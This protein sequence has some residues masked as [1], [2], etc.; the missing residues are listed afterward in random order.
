MFRN[1]RQ[2]FCTFITNGSWENR[3]SS[4]KD[5]HRIHKENNKIQNQDKTLIWYDNNILIKWKKSRLCLLL[6][7]SQPM[8]IEQNI[9]DQW[10]MTITLNWPIR[11]EQIKYEPMRIKKS[12]LKDSIQSYEQK[13]GWFSSQLLNFQWSQGRVF[14]TTFAKKSCIFKIFLP[15]PLP[16]LIPLFPLFL[17]PLPFF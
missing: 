13:K 7:F 11:V 14:Y 3:I 8:K 1:N 12:V 17:P 5:V 15:Y 2:K 6:I 10:K 4:K 9:L 16:F